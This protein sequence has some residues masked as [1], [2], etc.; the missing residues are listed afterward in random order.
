METVAESAAVSAR[1][2]DPY[3]KNTGKFKSTYM[4][5]KPYT[6]AGQTYHCIHPKPVFRHSNGTIVPAGCPEWIQLIKMYYKRATAARKK[7]KPK[8]KSTYY[9]RKKGY[10]YPKGSYRRQNTIARALSALAR[11]P[12]YGGGGFGRQPTIIKL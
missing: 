10:A 5:S 1:V 7:A 4:D 9:K 12:S 2:F 6:L 11:R 3:Y 8:R